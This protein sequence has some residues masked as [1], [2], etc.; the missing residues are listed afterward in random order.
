[1]NTQ[2]ILLLKKAKNLTG[3]QLELFLLLVEGCKNKQEI[4]KAIW[5]GYI[6]DDTFRKLIFELRQKLPENTL[7]Y[8]KG[9]GY[10]INTNLL[11]V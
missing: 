10:F 6:C 3:R 7:V 2:Q 1:M 8:E 5:D 11:R 4:I 9:K